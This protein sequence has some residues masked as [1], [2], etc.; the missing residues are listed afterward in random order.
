MAS[1]SSRGAAV[2]VAVPLDA[3]QLGGERVPPGGGRRLGRLVGVQP[4]RHRHLRRVVAL[5]RLEVVA[6]GHRGV[7]TAAPSRRRDRLGVGRQP[8]VLGQ[9]DD[10]GADRRAAPARP[11]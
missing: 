7:T 4:D 10:V 5:Q 3:G 2:R 1:R 11:G 6:D 9:R 8:L